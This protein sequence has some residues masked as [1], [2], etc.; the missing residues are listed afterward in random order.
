MRFSGFFPRIFGI[1]KKSF[2]GKYY[3]KENVSAKELCNCHQC[4]YH[5]SCCGY[6]DLFYLC[7]AVGGSEFKKNYDDRCIQA[8]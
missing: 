5:R 7:A 1:M 8:E 2:G 6:S 4:V 3:E